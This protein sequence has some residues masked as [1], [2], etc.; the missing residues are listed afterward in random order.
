MFRLRTSDFIDLREDFFGVTYIIINDISSIHLHRR[1]G[2]PNVRMQH[3]VKYAVE[4]VQTC[5]DPRQR[6]CVCFPLAVPVQ[7]P[8][9]V[10]PCKRGPICFECCPSRWLDTPRHIFMLMVWGC[11]VEVS[12]TRGSGVRPIQ[13]RGLLVW[14][15]GCCVRFVC[16]YVCM[17]ILACMCVCVHV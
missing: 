14:K 16:V 12:G 11:R 10:G 4:R 3:T 2:E 8:L 15:P 9:N 13:G 17:C 5:C 7:N 1:E 6:V